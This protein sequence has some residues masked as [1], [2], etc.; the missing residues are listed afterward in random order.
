[1]GWK[2]C[3]CV[4]HVKCEDAISDQDIAETRFVC[5]FRRVQWRYPRGVK[6]P[7]SQ[8]KQLYSL[9]IR[10]NAKKREGQSKAGLVGSK[11]KR[12]RLK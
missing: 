12:Q 7:C 5:V 10:D 9:I 4:E 3:L 6:N 2:V 11:M 8:Q 1:M